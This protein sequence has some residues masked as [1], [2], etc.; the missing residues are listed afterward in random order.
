MLV[1]QAKKPTIVSSD[2]EEDEEKMV[3]LSMLDLS[4]IFLAKQNSETDSE[5]LITPFTP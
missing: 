3:R 1:E 5:Q 4:S 2:D